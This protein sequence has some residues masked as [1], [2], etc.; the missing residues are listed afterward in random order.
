M[1]VFHYFALL[2]SSGFGCYLF[3]FAQERGSQNHMKMYLNYSNLSYMIQAYRLRD[4][5]AQSFQ[6]F[7]AFSLQ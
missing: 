1:I 4:K 3:L 6:L 2:F 7:V 5:L